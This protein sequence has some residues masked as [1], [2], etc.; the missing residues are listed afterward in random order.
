MP[1]PWGVC[2]CISFEK[3]QSFE[4]FW[5]CFTFENTAPYLYKLYSNLVTRVAEPQRSL[6]L[7]IKHDRWQKREVELLIVQT[8]YLKA[9]S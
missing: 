6:L 3:S 1:I 2:V 8:H 7:Q 4:C 9:I 5:C